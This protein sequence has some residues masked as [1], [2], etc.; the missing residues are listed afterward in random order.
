MSNVLTKETIK[1]LTAE[2]AL[3]LNYEDIPESGFKLWPDG[4]YHVVFNEPEIQDNVGKDK[5]SRLAIGYKLVEV[6][7]LADPE[8]ATP[9]AEAVNNNGYMLPDG[10]SMF[11][12]DFKDLFVAT[13][14][15]TPLELCGALKDYHAVITLGH[16]AD[17]NDPDRI[18]QSTKAIA[19]LV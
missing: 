5:K 18:Y 4:T 15:K 9:E 13:G 8:G 10:I 6:M 14:T 19:P 7:E 11:R 3:N 2:E 17:K 12:T 16:R 1:S